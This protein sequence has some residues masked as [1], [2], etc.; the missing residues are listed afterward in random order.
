[1][2]KANLILMVA[3]ILGICKAQEYQVSD[4]ELLLMPTAYTMEQGKSYLTDY[5]LFL[6]N[7]TYAISPSTHLGVFT[8]FPITKDFLETFTLGAKQKYLNSDFIKAALWTTYTPKISGLTLGTVFSFGKAANGLHLGISTASEFET[9]EKHWELIYML[10]YR[11]DFSQKFSLLAEYTNFSSFIK[12]D[13][14][15]LISIGIRFRGES[16]A[17]EL[18]GVRPLESTGDFLF[19]PLLKATFLFD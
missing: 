3:F 18:A 8:L 2:R 15:G 4:H 10:G 12:E 5:E 13:F 14:N 6:L 1:M 7:Y 9:S 19:F 16:I 11:Y 17:W